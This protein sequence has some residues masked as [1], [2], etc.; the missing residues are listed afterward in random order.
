MNAILALLATLGAQ[1]AEEWV[2]YTHLYLA[3]HHLK[4][5]SWGGRPEKCAFPD[6]PAPPPKA[7]DPEKVAEL[8]RR[9]GDDDPE[10][11]DEAQREL[12]AMGEGALPAL[13]AT[14]DHADLEVRG[15]GARIAAEI[16]ERARGLGDVETTSLAILAFLGAG[17]SHISKDTYDGI[18]FGTVV[19]EGLAW[20]MARQ[21]GNGRFDPKDAVANALAALALTE[22]YGLTGS[23]RYKDAA[24]AGATAV[25]RA[26]VKEPRELVWKGMVVVSADLSGVEGKHAEQASAIA[27]ALRKHPALLAGAGRAFVR[28]HVLK[29]K[30]ERTDEIAKAAPL[31][32][33][34][35]TRCLAAMALFAQ[36]GHKGERWKAWNPGLKESL[37]PRQSMIK[38]R[39]ERGSWEGEG[40]RARL[41]ATSLNGMTLQV[42]YRYPTVFG[43]AK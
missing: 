4:D 7:P 18:C 23:A 15:R 11:R 27:E 10:R 14:R 12:G 5:G 40:V 16:A 13:K 35:E 6:A 43:A 30:D 38:G 31:G 39:C 22:A 37:V 29:E 1:E 41:R 2:S 3:R 36:E 25:E 21:D 9:V 42:Y 33:D 34:P 19:R 32:M 26:D 24:Q 28:A 8:S 20:L 17:Y